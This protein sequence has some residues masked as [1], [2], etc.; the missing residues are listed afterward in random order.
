MILLLKDHLA[1][2]I[3]SGLQDPHE[4]GAWKSNVTLI[5]SLCVSTHVPLGSLLELAGN[6][7]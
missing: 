5:Q 1:S 2:K 7:K 4:G 6:R 3:C